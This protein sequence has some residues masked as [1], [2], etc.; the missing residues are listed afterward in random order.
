MSEGLK[1]TSEISVRIRGIWEASWCHS[2]G[3]IYASVWP[4]CPNPAH[5]HQKLWA[6]I[7][8]NTFKG[9]QTSGIRPPSCQLAWTQEGGEKSLFTEA[10][11]TCYNDNGHN[12]P[13]WNW[14]P[15][16]R[17]PGKC[18]STPK[19]PAP[20]RTASQPG[21]KVTADAVTAAAAR[22]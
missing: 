17:A 9:N 8:I 12:H 21:T 19:S 18:D 15:C 5:L 4:G 16:S 11:F 2:R 14:S 13:A 7:F 22:N 6:G 10:A 3:S 20:P 1:I